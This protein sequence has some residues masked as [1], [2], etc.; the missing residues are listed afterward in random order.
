MRD[1]TARQLGATSGFLP[2]REA[3]VPAT[4]YRAI[5]FGL[6]AGSGYE[7]THSRLSLTPNGGRKNEGL[8]D[9]KGRGAVGGERVDLLPPAYARMSET[10]CRRVGKHEKQDVLQRGYCKEDTA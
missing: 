7:E 10:R 9:A 8:H 3:L 2:R 4:G 5:P 6:N 1:I